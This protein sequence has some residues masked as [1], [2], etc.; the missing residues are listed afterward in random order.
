M[1]KS[2]CLAAA[3]MRPGVTGQGGWGP[4]PAAGAQ[5]T[6]HHDRPWNALIPLRRTDGSDEVGG[7]QFKGSDLTRCVQLEVEWTRG[8]MTRYLTHP[9]VQRPEARPHPGGQENRRG[10]S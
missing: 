3:E 7:L 6:S 8:V 4:E 10:H 9:Y 5:I 1:P 2:C